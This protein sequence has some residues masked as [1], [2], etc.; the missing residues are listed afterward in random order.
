[1]DILGIGGNIYVLCK[2]TQTL[3]GSECGLLNYDNH[4]FIKVRPAMEYSEFPVR[5]KN[6][7][8]RQPLPVDHALPEQAPIL[9][10]ENLIS[11]IMKIYISRGIAFLSI[12]M[13]ENMNI[14][15]VYSILPFSEE[16]RAEHFHL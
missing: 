2:I 7:V 4:H 6:L 1:M 12:K 8:Y 11:E 13:D 5:I 9:V 10:D 15:Y 14:P 3:L 16:I